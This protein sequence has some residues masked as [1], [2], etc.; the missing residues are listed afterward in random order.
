MNKDNLLRIS[1]LLVIGSI[2]FFSCQKKGTVEEYKNTNGNILIRFTHLDND[3]SLAF[4]TMLYVTS[5]GNHYLVNDLQYFI[6]GMK[7]RSAAGKWI[8]ILSDN[9]IHYIEARD[10]STCTW[11][12]TDL[13]PAGTYDSVSFIF[14]L[15]ADDNISYRFPDPPERD[16]FLAGYTW[17]WISL[18]EAE[19]E[20][21][22]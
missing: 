12:V 2:F 20:M 22:K 4:D 15:D 14:G 8:Q 18:Y 10:T 5:I 19:P 7:L 16:M 21:E 3:N 1:A 6:S 17:R 13:I 11:K 9:G